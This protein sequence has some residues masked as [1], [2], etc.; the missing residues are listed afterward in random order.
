MRK[1]L[2]WI[3]MLVV[4]LS[5]GAIL[6]V[7]I[8]R[9][10]DPLLYLMCRID[11]RDIRLGL[12]LYDYD[13][14]RL[15]ATLDEVTQVDV[16]PLLVCPVTEGSGGDGYEYVGTGLKLEEIMNPTVVP[17]VFD[18]RGNHPN[19]TRTVA[20]AGSSGQR[21]AVGLLPEKE[22]REVLVQAIRSG[23]YP[24]K[25]VEELRKEEPWVAR[26]LGGER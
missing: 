1:R 13:F 2:S 24:P 26:E 11:V 22:F 14:G 7:I 25:T 10:P 20:W 12:V 6:L 5:A 19:G 16:K 21:E 4:G 23:A 3:L 8:G 9:R 18:R 15:P 17:L